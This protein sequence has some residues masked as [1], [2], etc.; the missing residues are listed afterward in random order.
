MLCGC[1][2]KKTWSWMDLSVERIQAKDSGRST[3]SKGVSRTTTDQSSK[4]LRA[5]QLNLAEAAAEAAGE[6]SGS[7]EDDDDDE[8]LAEAADHAGNKRTFEAHAKSLVGKKV[9]LS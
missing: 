9:E 8:D 7:D 6:E 4:S 2:L 5:W 3:G 1:S